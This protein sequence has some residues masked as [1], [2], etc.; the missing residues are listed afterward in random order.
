MKLVHFNTFD[1]GGGAAKASRALHRAMLDLDVDATLI[2]HRKSSDD[3]SVIGKSPSRFALFGKRLLPW[4]LSAF[5]FILYRPFEVWSFGILGNRAITRDP[6]VEAADIISLS[7]VAWFLDVE[8]IGELLN[9]NRPVVWTCYDMW[10][11]TGGC[12]YAGECDNYTGNC[13]NCPQLG[14]GRERDISRWLWEKKN[15]CWDLSRL[16]VVCPSEWLAD[17]VRNSGLLG[18]IRVE[19]I[20]T[21]IDESVFKPIPRDTAREQMGLPGDKKLVLFIASRGFA[22]E[23]KG[24]GLL[25]QSLHILHRSA[26]VDLPDIVI[27]GHRQSDSTVHDVFTVHSREFNDD[28]SLAN[29]YAACDVSVIPSKADNLPLTVLQSMACGTPCVAFDVGGMGSAIDHLNSGYLAQAFDTEDFAAGISYLL[30]DD[31][32]R[33]AFSA[34]CVAKIDAGFTSRQEARRHLNLYRELLQ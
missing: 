31:S 8:A 4:L 2:V 23:R 26:Q 13:G 30:A 10:A 21:G 17:S 20:P 32:R 15:K 3:P 33:E 6:R 14:S 19:V 34:A 1:E 27:L 24:G 22:N 16:T 7:W 11:F 25:E 28:S 29:L 9:K 5:H 12:H 18:G